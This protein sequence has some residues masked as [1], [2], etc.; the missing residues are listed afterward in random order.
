MHSTPSLAQANHPLP[1]HL[2]SSQGQTQQQPA[3]AGVPLERKSSAPGLARSGSS[4]I[5][6]DE[7][8]GKPEDVLGRGAYA[9]VK[10]C[11]PINS[12][13]KYAIKEFRKRRKDETQKEYVKKLISEFCISSS[14]E[15]ENVVKTVDLIQDSK[16][17]WCV[18]MEYCAGGDLFAR[19]QNGSL[20]NYSEMNCYFMQLVRGVH[21][22]H[23]MG[24]SHRDLKP[25]NLLLD[26][27]GRLLKITDFGVSQVFRDPFGTVSKKTRGVA[28]SGPYIAPEEFSNEEYDPEAVDVWSIGIIFFVIMNNSILWKTAIPS[29][30]RYKQYLDSVTR[31]AP[32]ERLPYGAKEILY[33]ILDPN[34]KT[35][36]KLPAILDDFWCKS[37]S[38]CTAS[39]ADKVDHRHES[40]NK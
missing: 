3:P 24:V 17:Q 14:L 15:H 38:V 8:Y 16:R 31:F 28:G 4:D 12:K 19:I 30:P 21:Y 36:I 23:S 25:E 20:K 26:S 27:T 37:I 33:K 7:K 29:D 39:N 6:L 22:L 13:Q 35:R 32:F 11:C 10:L 2:Q 9:T 18:V 40:H 5:S 1:L 34:P